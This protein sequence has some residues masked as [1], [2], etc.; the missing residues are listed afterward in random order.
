MSGDDPVLVLGGSGQLGLSVLKR[1]A[2]AGRPTIAL[3]RH[4]PSDI[5]FGAEWL[6]ADL[7]GPLDLGGRHIGAAIHASSAWLLPA[8][9][10]TLRAAGVRRLVCFSSTSM[11][12]K[13]NSPSVAERNTA[14]RLA[15]AEKAVAEAPI[16]WTV[17]RPTLIYGL[18]RDR[19]VTAAA[20]FIRRWRF[21]PLAGPGKGLRQPVHADDLAAAAVR[22][23][24]DDTRAGRVF[25]IGGGET[26]TYRAMIERI[27]AVLAIK[28]RFL[29]L[30][31]LGALPGATGAMARRMEQ[32]LVF[33][34]GEVW[35]ELGLAP[36]TFLSS[37]I[38][39]LG[40]S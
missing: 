30:A 23:I 35:H 32:D 16:A 15:A 21:F 2:D 38:S 33:D 4:P 13:V 3:C 14:A 18:G 6:A 31:A 36:R 12:A 34:H 7:T 5:A 9:L 11:L 39:D 28:P 27:F 25:N 17:L 24:D 10:A 40:G 1:L 37:G 19:N 22:L 26:M 29:R 8:H 20:H